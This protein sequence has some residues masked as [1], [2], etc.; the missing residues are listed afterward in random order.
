MQTEILIALQVVVVL[1]I[2]IV[3]LI[4]IMLRQKSII[5]QLKTI[6]T[7]VKDDISGENL[8]GYLQTELDETAAQCKQDTVELKPDLEANDMAIALRYLALQAELNLLLNNESDAPRAWR[9][10]IEKY[11]ALAEHTTTIIK[12]RVDHATKTLNS[13]HNQELAEK[14]AKIA[15]L[16]QLQQHLELQIKELEPLKSFIAT[17]SE[18]GLSRNELEQSL[19]KALLSICENFADSGNFR[20]LVFLIHE[21]YNEVQSSKSED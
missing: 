7:S 21:S 18:E 1:I 17:S 11:V 10:K 4:L 20:E 5:N 15:E 3:V 13:S 9:E 16:E 19:H 6:L 2:A 12:Q 14:D 8:T